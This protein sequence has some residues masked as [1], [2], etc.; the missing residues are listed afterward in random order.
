MANVRT[1]KLN[2]LGDVSSFN[3]SMNTASKNT[4][5]FSQDVARNMKIATAA[6]GGLAIAFGVSAVK[7]AIEDQKSQRQLQ[8]ALRNTTK[9]TD[10][11][12]GKVEDWIAAQGRLLGV[13]DD[14]LRPA[15]AKLVRV[16]GDVNKS[17]DL[18][19]LAMDIAAGTGKSLETVTGAITRA[20]QGNLAG[21]KKLGIPLS[22]TIIKNKDLAEALKIA[23]KRFNGAA[24]AAGDTM[25]GKLKKFK[26]AM[27]ESKESIG[28]AIL[29]GLQPFAEKW[30][31][32]VTTGV[33]HFIDGLTGQNNAGGLNGA[34][35]DNQTSIYKLG[36]DITSFFKTLKD[37]E[38]LLKRI[39]T[40]IGAI[41]IGAKATAA[42]TA[43][44]TAVKT[45]I[46]AFRAVTVAAGTTAAAEAAATGGASLAVA[47]PAIL[48]IAT[49]LSLGSLVALYTWKN[50]P[51]DYS[52]DFK[53]AMDPSSGV[54]VAKS[55]AEDLARIN[56]S[57]GF[58]GPA[59][60]HKVVGGIDYFWDATK[61][62]W[63]SA[64]ISGNRDYSVQPK[65]ITGPSNF[66]ARN[67]SMGGSPVIIN[68]NGIVDGESARRSIER[69]L[70]Q[71]SIR[72][73]PLKL[74]GVAI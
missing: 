61:R 41:F 54:S 23:D 7:A 5:S 65:S 70:Q 59:G 17:Q 25:A 31:P 43:M 8:V 10:K 63:Y 21:L 14:E 47:A 34:L 12:L 26:T 42:A 51:K 13:T 40:V 68:L 9:A 38:E 56:N 3:K 62:K 11:Q 66:R 2:L 44:G 60:T 45:L 27:D 19:T 72:T 46:P 73:G 69:A 24:K 58:E 28:V 71:S 37:N 18:L 50:K 36:Q 49:A 57:T 29:Q 55:T 16:T 74:D 22:D 52:K 39:A 67:S 32:K 30:L 48:G 35:K 64:D 33:Q 20:Q 4:N 6:V 53:S 1:L 15:L